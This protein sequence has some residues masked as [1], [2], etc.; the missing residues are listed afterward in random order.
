LRIAATDLTGGRQ[1]GYRT[2]E[3]D[4]AMNNCAQ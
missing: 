1:R 4:K 2:N 3:A